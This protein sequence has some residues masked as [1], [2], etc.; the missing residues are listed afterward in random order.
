[1]E[2]NANLAEEQSNE[3]SAETLSTSKF[4]KRLSPEAKTAMLEL[5][6]QLNGIE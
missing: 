1:M 6:R 3:F 4:F 2:D 5:L